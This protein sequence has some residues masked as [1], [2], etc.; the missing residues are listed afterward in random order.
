MSQREVLAVTA[1]HLRYVITESRRVAAELHRLLEL[2]E[3]QGE[4]ADKK[5]PTP[6]IPA[7]V[8]PVQGGRADNSSD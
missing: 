5:S 3:G 7:V 2:S 1:R 4:E 6:L 8:L